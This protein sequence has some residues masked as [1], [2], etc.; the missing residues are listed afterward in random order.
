M[1]QV[2]TPRANL[3]FAAVQ[4]P[5]IFVA[6]PGEADGGEELPGVDAGPERDAARDDVQLRPVHQAQRGH[7]VRRL[8]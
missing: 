1:K 5:F 2:S 8:R 7:E 3:L 4:R 6:E